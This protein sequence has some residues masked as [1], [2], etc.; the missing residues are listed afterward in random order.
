MRRKGFSRI[1]FSIFLIGRCQRVAFAAR[2]HGL[3]IVGIFEADSDYPE[4]Q[5]NQRKEQCSA[6]P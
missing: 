5:Q 4:N 6:V 2:R 3:P 1:P